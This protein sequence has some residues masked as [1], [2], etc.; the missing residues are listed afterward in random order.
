MA[1]LSGGA[2]LAA[3]MMLVVGL[4]GPAQAKLSNAVVARLPD[5]LKPD[6]AT[7]FNLRAQRG[8]A[9]PVALAR[10]G[11]PLTP[12]AAD[13]SDGGGKGEKPAAGPAPVDDSTEYIVVDQSPD[14]VRAV[15][16]N[17][18]VR[19]A[20]W[21]ARDGL[22]TV[23]LP[24][25]RIVARVPPPAPFMTPG[26][27]AP[28][29]ATGVYFAPGTR[30]SGKPSRKKGATGWLETRFVDPDKRFRS[31]GFVE[32]ALL[33]T[34]YPDQPLQGAGAGAEVRGDARI[35]DAPGGR[36]LAR[37]TKGKEWVE[38]EQTGLRWQ[39]FYFVR[40]DLGD[41][42]LRGWVAAKAVRDLPPGGIGGHGT[43]G[44]GGWG[45][46]G[47]SV[48]LP[49][50]TVLRAPGGGEPFGVLLRTGYYPVVQR[51]G[52]GVEP[53]IRL[54]T[55]FGNIECEPEVPDTELEP[56]PAD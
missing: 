29:P 32:Q 42:Q 23:T 22:A 48:R 46:P 39:G 50:G 36:E 21:M 49:E 5:Y 7:R 31:A 10:D 27:A 20:L 8:F 12:L 30:L 33:G 6:V 3:G 18:S 28:A 40:I 54:Y 9:A 43:F 19:L 1:K 13:D 4:A 24:E 56:L 15:Y 47:R 2:A 14:R 17:A 35:L 45:T 25:A 34:V 51:R 38:G 53:I 16:A 44:T 41:V 37:L 52:R 55:P 11:Q 26:W